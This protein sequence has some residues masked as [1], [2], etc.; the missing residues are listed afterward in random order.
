MEP[1]TIRKYIMIPENSP[2]W[3]GPSI[4]PADRRNKTW[5]K[6]HSDRKIFLQINEEQNECFFANIKWKLN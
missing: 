3:F 5:I 1:D 2:G 6:V 4:D